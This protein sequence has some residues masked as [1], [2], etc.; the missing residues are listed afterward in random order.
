MSAFLRLGQ[1]RSSLAINQTRTFVDFSRSL[2]V[3]GP[4]P[5]PF[6]EVT[7]HS[8]QARITLSTDY[9]KSESQTCFG[10][11][12]LAGVA[13]PAPPTF[14]SLRKVRA[15]RNPNVAAALSHMSAKDLVC[16]LRDTTPPPTTTR[17]T[18]EQ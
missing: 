16:Q 15:I 8:H 4:P 17:D 9:D 2:D 14:A 13:P 11:A 7:L 5:P 3:E 18:P 10:G 6:S 12:E 1:V